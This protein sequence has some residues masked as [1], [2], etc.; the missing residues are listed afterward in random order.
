[1][2]A[3]TTTAPD[4]YRAS[5]TKSIAVLGFAVLASMAVTLILIAMALNPGPYLLLL[6]PSLVAG[7][8]LSIL[9]WRILLGARDR[10]SL[11]AE[12]VESA[13]SS[14][15]VHWLELRSLQEIKS[16]WGGRRLILG[17]TQLRPL[18][19]DTTLLSSFDEVQLM[20]RLRRRIRPLFFRRIDHVLSEGGHF[21]TRDGA[22]RDDLVE[23]LIWLGCG[24]ALS[25]WLPTMLV[26]VAVALRLTFLID[27]S[28]TRIQIEG[29]AMTQ[30][31]WWRTIRLS[32]GSIRHV[33]Y[34]SRVR[35][36]GLS[37][38]WVEVWSDRQVLRIDDT[39]GEFEVL[40]GA[41]E[42][43][44]RDTPP[45]GGVYFPDEVSAT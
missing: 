45:R 5:L 41:V 35:L 28:S 29:R 12:G 36:V 7:V 38:R 30:R 17:S 9:A 37:R 33:N 27:R 23:G 1:M 25:S 20:D 21:T 3:S 4:V 42:G 43:L 40:T 22:Q 19:I 2:T 13:R 14:L 31:R 34:C 16:P 24:W 15:A 6:G 11:S 44:Q 8:C 39:L 10:I 26:A 18:I 32:A